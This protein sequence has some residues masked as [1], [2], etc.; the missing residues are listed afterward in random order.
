MNHSF[1]FIHNFY[2]LIYQT[3]HFS[4]GF[5]RDPTGQ[6]NSLENSGRFDSDPMTRKFGGE[7]GSFSICKFIVSSV[8]DEHQTWNE[9]NLKF[10]SIA[11]LLKT[12]LLEQT[13]RRTAADVSCLGQVKEECR[14]TAGSGWSSDMRGKQISSR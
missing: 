6:L 4:A 8:I 7:C 13:R 2:N 9:R 12:N 3:S 10:E 5:M 1:V 14:M 11:T